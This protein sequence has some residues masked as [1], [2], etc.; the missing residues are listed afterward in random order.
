MTRPAWHF[1]VDVFLFS[2][3]LSLLWLS[4]LLQFVFPPGTFAAG[5][6]LWGIGYDSWSTARFVSLAIFTLC[7]LVHLI[8]Q[9]NWVCNFVSS[10]V[11][12][13]RGKLSDGVKTAY[14]V[15][16]LIAVLCLI[17]LSL[18]VAAVAVRRPSP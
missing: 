5:W 13:G 9:W 15:S 8:L 18:F 7:T 16:T 11:A 14:G 3:F 12:R 2:A 6:T 17:G 1:L 4:A 10:R